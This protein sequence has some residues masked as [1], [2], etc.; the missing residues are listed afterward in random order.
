MAECGLPGHCGT[1]GRGSESRGEGGKE[2]GRKRKK[3]R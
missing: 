2:E 3:E 1:G